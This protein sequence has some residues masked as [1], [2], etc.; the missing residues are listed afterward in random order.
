MQVREVWNGDTILM[1]L[2]RNKSNTFKS[3][4]YHYSP[5]FTAF[6]MIDITKRKL[7]ESRFDL[8]LNEILWECS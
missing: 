2:L 8:I 4:F 7:K 3:I 5:K 6:S 1:Y